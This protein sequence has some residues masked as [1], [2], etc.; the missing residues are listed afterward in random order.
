MWRVWKAHLSCTY[1]CDVSQLFQISTRRLATVGQNKIRL[2]M[3]IYVPHIFKFFHLYSGVKKFNNLKI[4]WCT[5]FHQSN[6][7]LDTGTILKHNTLMT[8]CYEPLTFSFAEIFLGMIW[9]LL[10]Q[11]WAKTSLNG[12][13]H[14]RFLSST[15]W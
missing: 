12:V 2:S 14:S 9:G 8:L 7:L 13:Y 6:P 10:I 15:F 5:L 1:I 3:Q 11:K 4:V